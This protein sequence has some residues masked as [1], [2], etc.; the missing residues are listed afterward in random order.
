MAAFGLDVTFAAGVEVLTSSPSVGT[1][2]WRGPLRQNWRYRTAPRSVSV[3]TS[4]RDPLFG[5]ARK[6]M[7]PADGTNSCKSSSSGGL[8]FI[9]NVLTFAIA[10]VTHGF[11][12]VTPIRRVANCAD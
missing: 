3:S 6:A 7:A 11:A 1:L 2:D 4:A 8:G 10:E 5:F 12:E 9:L